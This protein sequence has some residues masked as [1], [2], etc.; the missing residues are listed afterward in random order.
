MIATTRG[1][2][3]RG[4]TTDALGDETDN[5]VEPVAGAVDFPISITEKDRREFDIASNQWRAVRELVGRVS[6]RLDVRPGDRVRDLRDGR[7]YAVDGIRRTARGMSGRASVTL[8][9]RRTGS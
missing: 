3:Y 8:T 5:N 1:T 6:P 9:L 7:I 4:T 2:L